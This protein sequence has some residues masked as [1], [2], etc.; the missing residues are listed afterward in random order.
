MAGEP[1]NTGNCARKEEFMIIEEF[2]KFH[3]DSP[4]ETKEK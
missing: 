2:L 4:A 3:T 1:G